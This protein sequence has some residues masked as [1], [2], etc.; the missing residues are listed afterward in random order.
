MRKQLSVQALAQLLVPKQ[1]PEE[2]IAGGAE[3]V[4]STA[5]CSI[6]GAKNLYEAHM[7]SRTGPKEER[8]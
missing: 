6:P 5:S 2:S 1:H 3:R 8:G 7:N 4:P